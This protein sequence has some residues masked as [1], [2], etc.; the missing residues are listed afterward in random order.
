M[1]IVLAGI[2]QKDRIK[3]ITHETI[4]AIYP[5]YYAKGAVD[6]FL[7]HHCS[8][9]IEHDI[10]MQSV[11]VI[12]DGENTVG[13]VTIKDNEVCRLFVLP[14]YQHNGFGQAL[15][16]FAEQMVSEQWREVIVD[17]SLSA[18]CLYKKRG[19]SEIEYHRIATDNGDFLCYDVMKKIL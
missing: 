1:E 12:N 2:E 19:Y 5:H 9:N 11:Y 4:H 6:F 7:A 17:A 10:R 3:Y 16:D 18:K 13:T 15:L 8:E 14:E